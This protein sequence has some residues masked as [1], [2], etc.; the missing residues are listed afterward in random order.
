MY[1]GHPQLLALV[2]QM[3]LESMPDNDPVIMHY[4]NELHMSEL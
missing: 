1:H 2:H 4:L 3:K